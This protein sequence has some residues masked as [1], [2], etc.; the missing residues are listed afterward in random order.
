M[1][2]H[3]LYAKYAFEKLYPA[4]NTRDAYRQHLKAQA[5]MLLEQNRIAGSLLVGA[6]SVQQGLRVLL[7]PSDARS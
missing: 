2:L 3:I 1:R 7:R 6:K 4:Y 5:D